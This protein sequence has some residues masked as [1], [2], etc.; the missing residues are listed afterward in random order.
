MQIL[1]T[2][3]K[4]FFLFLFTLLNHMQLRHSF[5]AI[6]RVIEQWR[7]ST[8]RRLGADLGK[9]AHVR[10]NSFITHPAHLKL[11]EN[12]KI[13]PFCQ[14]FLY[15]TLTIGNDVEIGSGL[16]VHTAEHRFDDSDKLLARQGTVKQP[17]E[18]ASDVY[19]GSGVTLLPG[20]TIGPRSVV[21][22]GSV[23]T[24][25]LEGGYVYAGNPARQIR[26]TVARLQE[27]SGRAG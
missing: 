9:N 11:G 6:G 1:K 15:D 8:L 12:S 13:G 27:C 4:V 23:V 19:L 25:K 16:V 26:P 20:A 7:G 18:I 14:L 10:F 22:A 5:P 24:R 2:I 21:G 3:P 17:V